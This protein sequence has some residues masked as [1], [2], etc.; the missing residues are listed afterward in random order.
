[1]ELRPL[2][3]RARRRSQLAA[4]PTAPVTK[5]LALYHHISAQ[6]EA[7]VYDDHTDVASQHGLTRASRTRL[8]NLLLSPPTLRRRS[9]P[10][11]F[12]PAGSRCAIGP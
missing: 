10:S 12:P 2:G 1:M 7:A 9:R 11:M 5:R 4:R 8:M 3:A 6:I